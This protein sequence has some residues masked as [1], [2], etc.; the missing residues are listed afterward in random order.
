MQGT[1]FKRKG[2]VLTALPTDDINAVVVP[3]LSVFQRRLCTHTPPPTARARMCGDVC[4]FF[5]N[6]MDLDRD[7]KIE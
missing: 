5:N 4:V 6:A 3:S 2:P 7:T 1:E